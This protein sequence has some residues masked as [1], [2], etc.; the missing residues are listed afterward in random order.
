MAMKIQNFVRSFQNASL[1]LIFE[2]SYLWYDF[3]FFSCANFTIAAPGSATQDNQP[4]SLIPCFLPSSNGWMRPDAL[5]FS[6]R[7]FSVK[8]INSDCFFFLDLPPLLLIRAVLSFS[9]M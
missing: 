1:L 4:H 3:E 2:D 9:T 7:L 5:W 6:M 8:S